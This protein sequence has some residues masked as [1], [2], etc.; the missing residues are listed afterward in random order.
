MSEQFKVGEVAIG[1]NFVDFTEHN[2]E[3]LLVVGGLHYG[4]WVDMMAL[5]SCRGMYYQ[6]QSICG[7]KFVVTPHQ[8]RRRKPPSATG[9]QSVLAMFKAPQ[10]VGETV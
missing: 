4:E 3:D 2:G 10:R 8:L 7:E 1:Q 9:E 5:E 6:V